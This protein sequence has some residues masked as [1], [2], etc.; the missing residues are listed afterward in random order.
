M[1]SF[2][3]FNFN[4]QKFNCL[5]FKLLLKIILKLMQI[6]INSLDFLPITFM[7]SCIFSPHLISSFQLKNDTQE[8]ILCVLGDQNLKELCYVGARNTFMAQYSNG[9][10]RKSNRHPGGCAPHK[11]PKRKKNLHQM[12][13]PSVAATARGSCQRKKKTLICLMY[14]GTVTGHLMMMNNS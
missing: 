5:H 7:R 6:I 3:Y 1:S 14:R 9:D 11:R 13:F 10:L 12:L 8:V 2:R 4:F